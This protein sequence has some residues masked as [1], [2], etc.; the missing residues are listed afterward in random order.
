MSEFTENNKKRT[1]VLTEYIQ[2]LINNQDWIKMLEKY[3]ISEITFEPF[4]VI[5]T[6]DNVMILN[7]DIEKI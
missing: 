7:N 4:E 5:H 6:L 3:K 1:K 2:G